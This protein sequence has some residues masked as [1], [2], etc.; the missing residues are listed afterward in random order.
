MKTW[1]GVVGLVVLFFGSIALF[2]KVQHVYGAMPVAVIAMACMGAAWVATP[3]SRAITEKVRGAMRDLNLSVKVVAAVTG[4]T[5]AQVSRQLNDVDQL[6]LSRWVALGPQF[7]RALALRMLA[8]AGGRWVEDSLL[9][10]L[11][12][13]VEAAYLTPKSARRIA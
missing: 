5:E 13:S 1:L 8:G 9:A 11:V 3:E 10:R 2:A 12:N 4:M 7:E 6:S